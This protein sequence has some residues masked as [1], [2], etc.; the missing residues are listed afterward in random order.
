MLRDRRRTEAFLRAIAAGVN[1]GD[2]VVD[3]GCGTGILSFFS[4]LAGAERVYAVEQGPI[5][6]VAQEL[7]TA[8]GFDGRVEFVDGWS[9]EV[10][11][12]APV[13]VI[14]SET[15]GNAGLEEGIVRSVSDARARYLK[16]GGRVIPE[17]V[18]VMAAPVEVPFDAAEIAH[19]GGKTFAL[20]FSPLRA[21]AAR[22]LW[23][24]ELSP[25]HLLAEPVS[26][27][28]TLMSHA[29]QPSLSPARARA[30]KPGSVH[31]IGVW[32][33]AYLGW[34][35][36]IDN[37][38]GDGSASWSQVFLPLEDP[39]AV[40]AGEEI[41]IA[42]QANA[43]GTRWSWSTSTST[44]ESPVLDTAAGSLLSPGR[45]PASRVNGFAS[46]DPIIDKE[47]RHAK[48]G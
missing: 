18:T 32:F 39:I 4:C 41:D 36:A 13:D 21:I 30:S 12:P 22:Q 44:A 16:P 7:C 19:W 31:G 9:T 10:D 48:D 25:A 34:D 24:T 33:R 27:G 20:D 3:I 17:S 47:E 15:I 14:V 43:T 2:V 37:R 6:R 40:S 46:A 23:A 8:N 45:G 5:L 11:L 29:D 26:L 38:P 1:P 28:T 35:V 42:V